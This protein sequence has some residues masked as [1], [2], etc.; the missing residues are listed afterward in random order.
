MEVY[1]RAVGVLQCNASLLVCEASR[2]AVVVDPGGDASELLDMIEDARAR[3]E[4]IVVTHAH[5]DHFYAARE[6]RDALPEPRPPVV[7]H[8]D[9]LGLWGAAKEQCGM[10]GLPPRA[11]PPPDVLLRGAEEGEVGP[12]MGGERLRYIPTPGH[13]PGSTCFHAAGAR[14]L[15]AGDCLFR[16]SVGRTDLP[17]GSARQLHASVLRLYELP[18]E[19]RVI[20]GHGPETTIGHEMRFNPFVRPPRQ[21]L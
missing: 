2:R 19:T 10:V 9:D 13:T 14:L 18:P 16:G 7:L 20:T 17:G 11:V 6:L 1:T 15:L 8:E 3:V 21:K 12:E 5:I 4:A